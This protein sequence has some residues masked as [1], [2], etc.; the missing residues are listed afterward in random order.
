[1]HELASPVRLAPRST[2]CSVR[3]ECEARMEVAGNSPCLL[4]ASVSESDPKRPHR[5]GT[6]RLEVRLADARGEELATTDHQEAQGRPG[7]ADHR[8]SQVDQP[9]SQRR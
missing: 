7:R 5:A 1:M 6:C 2:T 8:P 9:P 3:T 4:T